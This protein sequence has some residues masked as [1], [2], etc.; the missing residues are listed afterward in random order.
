MKLQF[1]R[2]L[3]ADPWVKSAEK[4]TIGGAKCNI[5]NTPPHFLFIIHGMDQE[6]VARPSIF[7]IYPRTCADVQDGPIGLMQPHLFHAPS[8]PPIKPGN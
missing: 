2:V 3:E 6:P 7:Y 1:S 8:L 5:P 4:P